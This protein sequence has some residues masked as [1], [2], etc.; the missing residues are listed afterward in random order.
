MKTSFQH[1]VLRTNCID[2]LDRT[3]VAQYAFGLAALGRQ[4][5]AL[6][7]WGNSRA[8]SNSNLGITLMEFYE[9]MGDTLALQYGGS[10]AHNKVT[11]KLNLGVLYF[12]LYNWL[13]TCSMH[14]VCVSTIDVTILH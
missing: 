11:I 14:I 6:G 4:L 3:N 7:L 13:V 8:G 5:H 9:S 1:G 2:C 12:L 10:P